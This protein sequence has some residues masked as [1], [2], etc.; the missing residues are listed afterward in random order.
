MTS[1]NP[2]RL[3]VCNDEDCVVRRSLEYA[4]RIEGLLTERGE[5][6]SVEIE[7]HSCFGLCEDGP[8]MIVYPDRAWYV[9]VQEEDLPAV[10]DHLTGAGPRLTRLETA[11]QDSLDFILDVLDSEG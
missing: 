4:D 1:E 7:P 2:R 5:L 11:D 3:F 9:C 6:P 8:N 10:A